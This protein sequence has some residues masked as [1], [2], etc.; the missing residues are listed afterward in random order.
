[1]PDLAYTPAVAIPAR[2]RRRVQ[3]DDASFAW[4]ASR[5]A[6][7]LSLYVEGP[8]GQARVTIADDSAEDDAGDRLLRPVTPRLVARIIRWACSAGWRPEEPGLRLFRYADGWGE[9]EPE[10]ELDEREVIMLGD[11]ARL[12]PVVAYPVLRADAD[13]SLLAAVARSGLLERPPYTAGAL[14]L[15]LSGLTPEERALVIRAWHSEQVVQLDAAGHS[16]QDPSAIREH[17][18]SLGGGLALMDDRGQHRVVPR[19]CCTLASIHSWREAV[20]WREPER[21][22]LWTGHPWCEVR[23]R[24]PYLWIEPNTRGRPLAIH[25]RRLRRLLDACEGP[26][27]ALKAQAIEVLARRGGHAPA[28]AAAYAEACVG[29]LGLDEPRPEESP[30]QPSP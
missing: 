19:C 21:T 4:C 14:D 17:A 15:R 5:R 29:Y 6:E 28:V 18:A 25:P 24:A 13:A 2:M 27:R 26:L 8:R 7:G 12:E 16:P 20:T 11:Q 9:A 30:A 10:P 1:M 23:Y 3:V 22:E